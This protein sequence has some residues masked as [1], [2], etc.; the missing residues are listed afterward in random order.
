MTDCTPQ[1]D[2]DHE[3]HRLADDGCPHN[4][5]THTLTLD[6]YQRDAVRTCTHERGAKSPNGLAWT[7]LGLTGEAGEVAD[8][9]KKHVAHGHELDRAKLIAELG[10][11]LWYVAALA[12]CVGCDLSTLAAENT[13]KLRRRYPN[14]FTQSDS[15]NRTN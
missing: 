14:G 11:V 2:I 12:H 5:D 13:N 7:A 8:L 6:H 1:R 9:I 10:D 3:L 4:D 15:I